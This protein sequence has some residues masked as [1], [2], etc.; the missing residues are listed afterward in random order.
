ML[1]IIIPYKYVNNIRDKT[2]KFIYDYYQNFPNTEI[3]IGKDTT[4]NNGFNCSNAI[5]NAVKQSKGE[6]L[7]IVGADTII[8]PTAID[9]ALERLKKFPFIIPYGYIH[10]LNQK[11]SKK[12]I[13][14]R[15]I[16]F[17]EIERTSEKI[18]II[19]GTTVYTPK[20][21]GV[22][23]MTREVFDQLGGY[24]E[25]FTGWGWEDTY[26]CWKVINEIGDYPL[27]TDE[28]IYHLWHPRNKEKNTKEYK[29]N[30]ELF[31]SLGGD[32]EDFYKSQ[33]ESRDKWRDI[34]LKAVEHADNM[35]LLM[36][37][38]SEWGMI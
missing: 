27:L 30:Q 28:Y 38:K 3:I 1:S 2:F 6:Y 29:R 15:D 25:R 14:G 20:N 35:P 18:S 16:T 10:S 9:K 33:K 37:L 19:P 7:F 26:F 17:K 23:V 36:E 5:N 21:S 8:K 22:Q 4:N 24:D 34:V 31:K 11:I 12:I 13:K 32:L